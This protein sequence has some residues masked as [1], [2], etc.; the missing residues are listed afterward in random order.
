MYSTN[1]I[2]IYI[3]YIS[4]KNDLTHMVIV[5]FSGKKYTM[6][7]T[8]PSTHYIIHSYNIPLY[9]RSRK[10]RHLFVRT[11]VQPRALQY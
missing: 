4:L 9:P 11:K 6:T 10:R 7:S 5:Y 2:I 8:L 3:I 1:I